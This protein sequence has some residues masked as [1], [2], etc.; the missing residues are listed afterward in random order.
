MEELE[1]KENSFLPHMFF[2]EEYRKQKPL[3]MPF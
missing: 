1:N 2:N 3:E